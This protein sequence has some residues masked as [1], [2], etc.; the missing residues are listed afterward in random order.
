MDKLNI[1]TCPICG[2]THIKEV[3]NCKDFYA[4]GETFAICSCDICGFK[5]TQ[6]APVE[7]A[8]GRYY[9]T[10]DYI[11]HSDTKK[12]A[13][14]LVYHWVRQYMLGKKARLIIR[15]SHRKCGRLLDIGAGTG[16]F[17]NSMLQ[18]GWK[19]DAI[20]KSPQAREFAQT[21]FSIQAKDETAWDTFSQQSFDVITLWHVM[22][23]L[24]HLDETWDR[25]YNLLN[26]KGMLVVAVPNSASCD[27]ARYGKYWAAYDVPRHLWHFNPQTM[28]KIANKHGFILAERYPMPFDAFY[29][30]ILSEKH[31]KHSFPFIRGLW[32]GFK[33]YLATINAKERS[34]SMIYILRKK[35]DDKEK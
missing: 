14:N 34:S 31:L 19:V 27:A 29:I 15:L 22:E 20:E 25:L 4:T 26:A 35:R 13:M 1:T 5:F 24:E 21:H 32:N 16:Y 10:P 17:A 7:A 2:S 28:Q 9:E 18:R 33:A 6:Q 12:G 3:L 23:H 11:S 30:S 8:I